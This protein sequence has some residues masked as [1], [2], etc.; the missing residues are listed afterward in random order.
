MGIIRDLTGQRFGRL[1]V[2]RMGKDKHTPRGKRVITWD[3]VC[4][5]GK[6]TNVRSSHITSGHTW[7]CG[8]A[9]AE[10]MEAWKTL[11]LTH[12]KTANKQISKSYSRW[13]QI[14][15][16]CNNP[17]DVD[18]PYY[19]AKGIRLWE[20]WEN[21]PTDFCRYVEALEGYDITGSTIDRVDYT[22]NYEPGN[23]RWV[24]LADQQRNKRNN[25]WISAFGETQ[26]LTDWARETGLSRDTIKYR[27]KKGWSAEKAI[28][29]PSRLRK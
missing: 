10:Q 1:T 29:T 27:I 19:G 18:Y 26:L 16:R 12:G 9:H 13:T 5:C 15:Q 25:I 22:K 7:S 4:D 3:C 6:T 21:N 14:K 2:L 11:K 23:L 24:S 28:G 8:C 17:K 20:G